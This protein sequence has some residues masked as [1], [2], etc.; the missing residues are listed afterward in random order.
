M[1][2]LIKNIVKYICELKKSIVKYMRVKKY[3]NT[4]IAQI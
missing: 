2:E 3:A 4:I 1:C